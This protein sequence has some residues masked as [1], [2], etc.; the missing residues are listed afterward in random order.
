MNFF[1]WFKKGKKT[2]QFDSCC[3]CTGTVAEKAPQTY[4][5]PK[6]TFESP[7][8]GSIYT[9]AKDFGHGVLVASRQIGDGFT[10]IRI[11][12]TED[13]LPEDFD[14]TGVK[15]NLQFNWKTTSDHLSIVVVNDEA[16]TY[17]GYAIDACSEYFKTLGII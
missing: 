11:Q 4:R 5:S 2:K 3:G 15:N 17:V 6:E 8:T 13:E 9:V 7:Q 10:R 12:Y 16:E 1:G 14:I